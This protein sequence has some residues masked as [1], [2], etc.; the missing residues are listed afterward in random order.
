MADFKTK[1][2]KQF[3]KTLKSFKGEIKGR[4]K[5]AIINAVINTQGDAK[6]L[7]TTQGSVDSGRLRSSI[8]FLVRN[9][10]LAGEVFTDVFYAV[11]VEFGTK[12]HTIRATKAQALFW[13]GAAHPVVSV[14]HP[15]TR[16]RP[17]LFPA[18]Q[19]AQKQLI[20]D[21]KKL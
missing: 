4:A 19:K 7:L 2:F 14:E 18:F 17:F 20:K 6:R 11:F 5:R 13:K 15:G 8:R 10:G 9:D 21:M 12:R 16:P 3:A 1:G